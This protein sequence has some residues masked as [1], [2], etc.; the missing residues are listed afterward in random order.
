MPLAPLKDPWQQVPL[1]DDAD[2]VIAN[3]NEVP[4]EDS[5]KRWA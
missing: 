5:G 3:N 1:L 2:A 4:A